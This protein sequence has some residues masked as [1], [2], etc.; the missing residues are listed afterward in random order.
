LVNGKEL[1]DKIKDIMK[2]IEERIRQAEERLKEIDIHL[3]IPSVSYRS[4]VVASRIGDEGLSIIDMLIEAGL[5]ST[6]SEAVAYLVG[7]GIKA[8]KD[9]IQ[10]VSSSLKEI[11]KVRKE[12]EESI[13]RLKREI[14]F[15]EP[16]NNT[17]LKCNKCGKENTRESKFCS[18]CGEDL[19]N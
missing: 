3:S 10:K 18:D 1:G 4:N 7:E 5:F 14:G 19:G 17:N 9:I 2:N 6:R 11:R 8:R 15:V 12:A 13:L 16:S